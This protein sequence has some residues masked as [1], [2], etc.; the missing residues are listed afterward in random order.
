M[1]ADIHGG[2]EHVRRGIPFDI[3]E[4]VYEGDLEPNLLATQSG[5]GGQGG[6]L[7]E[8]AGKLL[9][10]F[11]K[12]RARQRPLPRFAP[13]E[14]GLLDQS[15]FGA[16]TRQKFRPVLRQSRRIGAQAFRRCERVGR[17]EHPVRACHRQHLAQGR[18]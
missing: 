18:A 2:P 3:D 13:Q 8:G 15:G 4:G 10:R 9:C 17:V 12:C 7:I 5:S 1:R 11:N 6:D 14:R 16:V